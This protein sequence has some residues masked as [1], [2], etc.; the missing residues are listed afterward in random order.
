VPAVV[1]LQFLLRKKIGARARYALWLPVALVLVTPAFPESRWSV[2]TVFV[3]AP[4]VQTMPPPSS[5]IPS[6]DAAPASPSEI[7]APSIDWR[8]LLPVAWLSGSV[9]LIGLL[10]FSHIRSLRRYAR[11]QLPVSD[12]LHAGIARVSDNVGLRR[13]PRVWRSP[14]V[15]SPAVTNLFRPLLLL[16][17][18]FEKHFTPREA[19]LILQHELTH[20]KRHDLSSNALMC[21]LITLHW[22]N[23]VLWLAFFRIRADREA[24]CDAQILTSA[25]A[26]QRRDYGHALLKVES[27]LTPA[28]LTLGFI[29]LFHRGAALRY[30]IQS[31]ASPRPTPLLMKLLTLALISSLT[32]LGV[33]RAATEPAP[34]PEIHLEARFIEITGER[35]QPK[36]ADITLEKA[37]AN[38]VKTTPPS[39]P[40]KALF[41]DSNKQLFFSQ[42]STLKG[43]DLMAAPRMIT[44]SGQ[45][46]Q[47]EVTREFL[48]SSGK[49]FSVGG[50]QVGVTLDVLPTLT[51]G[52]SFDLDIKSKV[53]EFDGFIDGPKNGKKPVFNER[54]TEARTTLQSGQTALI[55]IGTRDDTQEVFEEDSNGKILS[56]HQDTFTRRALVL[57]TARLAKPA[58]ANTSPKAFTP[59][60][61]TFRPGD[62]IRIRQVRR[63]NGFM[64]VTADYELASTDSARLSLHITSHKSNAGI[65][66]SQTQS[67]T[68]TRGKGSVILHHLDLYEGLPLIAFHNLEN[69]KAI[70]GLH[71]GSPEQAAASQKLDLSC[72]LEPSPE[73]RKPNTIASG[74]V[75]ASRNRAEPK[76][77]L[78]QYH[79]KKAPLRDVLRSLA[80]D[81]GWK[82]ISLSDGHPASSRLVTFSLKARPIDALQRICHANGLRLLFD[83][84]TLYVRPAD[85]AELVGKSYPHSTAT[86]VDSILSDIRALLGVRGNPAS[87]T[88]EAPKSSVIYKSA[89][90]AFY[91]NASRL[92]HTWAE[93][94]FT[95]LGREK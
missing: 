90:N 53:V 63:S 76:P 14:D 72:M 33:T 78:Q 62:D 57:V 83:G 71:F 21:L 30:R 52:V 50:P 10:G 55:D 17:A 15:H 94:Y 58:P 26:E 6:L 42:L 37:L 46:A 68:V 86:A 80:T 39:G 56:Q 77:S 47:V 88:E 74:D 29:G 85:D 87:R 11:T 2:Q 18:A 16:P 75:S 67:Q 84:N 27:A 61:S 12:S 43:V 70:G 19:R 38:V 49:P 24:A 35:N 65:K 1:A 92:Q 4:K 7:S 32:F 69:G 8:Q 41:D 36:S 31:I 81:A 89:D 66:T 60:K 3:T 64:T 73:E 44:R 25:D 23:P 34:G 45:R 95:A 54:K 51:K 91:V 22:F 93:A 20:L 40:V 82:F 5:E 9:I 13:P 48:D 59:G 28:P 79:F